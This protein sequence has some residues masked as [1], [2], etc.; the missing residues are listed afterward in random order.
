[1][2]YVYV[3]YVLPLTMGSPPPLDLLVKSM[4]KN[5]KA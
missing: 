2:Y 5:P 1:M 4:R 3:L